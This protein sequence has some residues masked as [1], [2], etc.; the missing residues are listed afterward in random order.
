M[1]PQQH[2]QAIAQLLQTLEHLQTQLTEA[3]LEKNTLTAVFK[4]A[5]QL[6]ENILELS[7]QDVDPS[8]VSPLQSYL[9]EIHKQMRLLEIDFRFLQTSRQIATLQTRQ[10]QMRSRSATLIRYCNSLLDQ[11]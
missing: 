8:L 7:D 6:F 4:Q 9:T 2:R 1:L 11:S 3:D 5:Q 10:A